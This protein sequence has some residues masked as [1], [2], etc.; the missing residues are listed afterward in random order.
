MNRTKKIRRMLDFR[1]NPDAIN[2][3]WGK[4]GMHPLEYSYAASGRLCGFDKANFKYNILNHYSIDKNKTI[5]IF[6]NDF[7]KTDI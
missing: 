4:K 2:L 5:L 6:N 3:S 7:P 1:V